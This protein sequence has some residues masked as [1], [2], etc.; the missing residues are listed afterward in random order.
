M[1]ARRPTISDRGGTAR[2]GL[3][4]LELAFCRSV[5]AS[6]QV[7]PPGVEVT[8]EGYQRAPTAPLV[9]QPN[10]ALFLNGLPILWPQ[11]GNEWGVANTL[12][13]VWQSDGTVAASSRLPQGFRVREGDQPRIAAQ[14]LAIGGVAAGTPR[15]YGTGFY[16]RSLYS[17]YPGTGAVFYM[18]AV[19][20]FAWEGQG[21][22][23]AAWPD[24]PAIAAG[25]CR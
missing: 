8:G 7:I 14:R 3:A 1:S 18:T 22:S 25:G 24:A 6:G 23:C 15:P 12:A 10:P 13:L 19:L 2:G 11:A 9:Q 21:Q 16:S 4:A 17:V 20:D 5:V